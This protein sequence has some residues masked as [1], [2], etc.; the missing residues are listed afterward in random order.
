MSDIGNKQVFAN[1]LNNLMNQKDIDRNELCKALNLKYSTV[2]EWISAKKYPRIDKI[3]LL[4]NYF[5]VP[6]SALI[7]ESG[8]MNIGDKIAARRKEL[9]LT[10]EQVGNFVGVGKSTVKKWETGYIANMRRDKIPMLAKILQMSP[11]EFIGETGAEENADID[12]SQI[13]NILPIKKI[14]IPMLGEI[15]CGTPIFADQQYEQYVDVN[16]DYNADFCLRAKGDSMINANIS[17]GDVVLIS[18]MPMVN[19]GEIAAVVIDNDATLKRVYYY[20]EKNKL[21]LQ[22]ENPAVEPLVYTDE[23]LDAIRILGKAV[24]VIKTL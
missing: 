14:R 7:E 10:L 24:A 11:T 4:A 6:K 19:N 1:N 20:R 17:N 8:T 21:I 9:G 18:E 15:A 13:G 12:F 22:A 3:E 16:E 23:E 5:G 2:S